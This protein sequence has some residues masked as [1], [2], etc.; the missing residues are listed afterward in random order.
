MVGRSVHLKGIVS[1]VATTL[2]IAAVGPGDALAATEVTAGS[3][4]LSAAPRGAED[5]TAV[6]DFWTPRRIE[7]APPIDQALAGAGAP[8]TDLPAAVPDASLNPV[9]FSTGGGGIGPPDR[10]ASSARGKII[11]DPTKYPN[12]VHGKMVGQFPGIGTFGCSATV[13]SSGSGSLLVSAGHC[14]YDATA[15]FAR[16]LA[17]APGYSRN[18]T[19]YGIWPVTNVI[20]PNGWANGAALDYDTS[21][22]RVA[23]VEG[24][25]LQDVVGSRGIGFKQPRKRRMK[26]F[27]YPAKGAAAYD[28]TTLV[29]CKSRY[30]KDPARNG[31]P[32]STGMR[33]DMKQ[34]A[35][36]GGWVSQNSFLV[37][38]TSHGYPEYSD[39]KMF[40]P[41]FGGAVR[42]L[43]TAEQEGWPSV[44]PVRCQGEVATIIGSAARDRIRGTD[45]ND[46]IATLGGRDV[47]SAS[48]G[49]DRIC[50]GADDDL[51]K[52]N[53]QNDRL[54]GGSGDDRCYGG[55][56]RNRF[57]TCEVRRG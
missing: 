34:G 20:V 25:R 46:V 44:G 3:D 57:R 56:G 28:G 54:V 29:M 1:A 47:V 2:A 43:Y 26:A 45:R 32:R 7:A 39:V 41:Y 18:S 33:C 30:V 9:P 22:M 40:G 55:R 14:A 53:A 48:K 38:E 24:R 31:G 19:P 16:N 15:G 5:P 6:E 50:G 42:S 23:E 8:S 36:G 13:V 21:L 17:F 35:S 10:F 11:Q 49:R 12:R 51:I 52:G 27:G 37:S 4:G